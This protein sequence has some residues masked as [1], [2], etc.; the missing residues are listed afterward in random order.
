LPIPVPSSS[1]D[2]AGSGK[3]YVAAK[4][5]VFDFDP[6]VRKQGRKRSQGEANLEHA[7]S[8]WAVESERLKRIETFIQD[9]YIDTGKLPCALTQVWRRGQLAYSRCWAAPMSSGERR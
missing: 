2:I 8:R 1:I 9:K 7:R 3:V 6:P 5:L 4:G